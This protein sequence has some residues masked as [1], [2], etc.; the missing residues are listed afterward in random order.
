MT[1]LPHGKPVVSQSVDIS[2][3]GVGIVT[4][5]HFEPGQQ[6][7]VAFALRNHR[8][9]EAVEKVIGRVAHLRAE[10]GG[11]LIGVEFLEPL[12]ESSAPLL[13]RKILSA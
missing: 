1:V 8:Q 5:G 7:A 3:G 9:Q 6:V 10:E 2:L 13:T 11:N 4:S 12:A